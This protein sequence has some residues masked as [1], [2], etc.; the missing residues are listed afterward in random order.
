MTHRRG[1]PVALT[2]LLI[3]AGCHGGSKASAKTSDAT[4]SRGS[5]GGT[6]D[7]SQAIAGDMASAPDGPMVDNTLL[8]HLS[9]EAFV[10]V[11]FGSRS[12]EFRLGVDVAKQ[13]V[14]NT[15]KPSP[16]PNVPL[17]DVVPAYSTEPL[18]LDLGIALRLRI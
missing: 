14:L 1:L 12:G 9:L 8:T 16:D 17:C 5:D 2:I 4:S 6:S 3:L 7:L 15:D 18:L 13:Y 11:H 10:G